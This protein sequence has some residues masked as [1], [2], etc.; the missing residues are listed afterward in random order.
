MAKD[1]AFLFY[2]GDW[3]GGTMGFSRHEKGAYIDL[4]MCQFNNSHMDAHMVREILGEKDFS[5]LWEKRLKKKFKI[6]SAGNFF[7]QKLEDEIVKRK[8]WTKSRLDNLSHMES[9]KE[10]H[11]VDHMDSHMEN[12]NEN[13]NRNRIKGGLGEN[14]KSKKPANGKKSETG[15]SGNFKS[16]GEELFAKRFTEGQDAVKRDRT[17]NRGSET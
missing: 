5:E 12:E 1:P 11:M 17:K 14:Q 8:K 16:Q 13:T 7:N 10:S 6:D 4:L 9:H 3:L 15:F 2:P